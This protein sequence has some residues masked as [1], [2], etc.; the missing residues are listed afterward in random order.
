MTSNSI[1]FYVE[2]STDIKQ[3]L[4]Y[5]V[6]NFNIDVYF[7]L[8]NRAG[9][10]AFLNLLYENRIIKSFDFNIDKILYRFIP[11]IFLM[12]HIHGEDNYIY[13]AY[14]INTSD[15]SLGNIYGIN[16]DAVSHLI[17]SIYLVTENK[18][19]NIV[20]G[21]ER[22]DHSYVITTRIED[23]FVNTITSDLNKLYK[24][25]MEEL[26]RYWIYN[27]TLLIGKA[28]LYYM[29]SNY[30]EKGKDKVLSFYNFDSYLNFCEYELFQ[31][32]RNTEHIT[33]SNGKSI[34]VGWD[35]ETYD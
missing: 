5:L 11:N 18:Y 1:D 4:N 30:F 31:F 12:R 19:Y 21:D 10:S 27:L 17:E 20:N 34:R 25:E 15:T 32:I 2:D 6:D 8:K 3:I 9:F 33:L 35:S 7:G 26:S 29:N 23:L 24:N 16:R 14:D 28:D 22:Y 13:C